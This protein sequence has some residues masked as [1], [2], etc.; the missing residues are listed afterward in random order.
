MVQGFAYNKRASRSKIQK[1]VRAALVLFFGKFRPSNTMTPDQ[2]KQHEVESKRFERELTDLLMDLDARPEI[3]IRAFHGVM[4]E[5]Q[6]EPPTMP[7]PTPGG[8]CGRVTRRLVP[9]TVRRGCVACQGGQTT[10]V[11]GREF[12]PAEGAIVFARTD[13]WLCMVHYEALAYVTNRSWFLSQGKKFPYPVPWTCS[14]D[15]NPLLAWAVE[16]AT[17]AFGKEPLATAADG[18]SAEDL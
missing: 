14:G 8:L 11:K 13:E 1:T 10:F 9:G 18:F 5:V 6:G 4:S 15:E 17:L 12:G 2:A 16:Y 3:I 7:M